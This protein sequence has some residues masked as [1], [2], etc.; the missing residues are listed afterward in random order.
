MN[1]IYG[2]NKFGTFY[3]KKKGKDYKKKMIEYILGEVEKQ[4]WIKPVDTFLYMDEIV[5]FNRKG[6]DADNL[7]KLQ[8]DSITESGVVWEDDSLALP[9][10][11]RILIDKYNP[12][13]EVVISEA[14]FVGVF[15]NQEHY[16]S[17]EGK[18][19]DCKRYKNNCSI[20]RELTEGRIHI[21]VDKDFNCNKYNPL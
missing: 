2:T 21:E 8:Q 14:P 13:V 9:R 16:E 4:S 15:D 12:R 18:C 20:L 10:T 1:S 5:Y 11:N 3:L 17:F 7:K 19:K 6:R